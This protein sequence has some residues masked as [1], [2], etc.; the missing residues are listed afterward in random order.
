MRIKSQLSGFSIL[1]L[2]SF[3]IIPLSP[4]HVAAQVDEKEKAQQELEKRKELEHKTLAL[5]DEIVSGAWGLKLPENRSFFLANAADL[6]W[7]YDEKRARNLFWDALNNL[8]PPANLAGNEPTGSLTKDSTTRAAPA[9]DSRAKPPGKEEQQKLNQYYAMFGARREFLRKVAKHDPQLALDMLRSARLPPPPEPPNANFHA[10][11]ERDLEQEIA[12]EAATRDPKRALQIVRESLAKGVTFQL[13]KLLFQLNQQDQEV[14]SEL[15][16][17]IIAKLDGESMETN[18]LVI[19]VQL[20]ESSRTRQS[21]LGQSEPVNVRVKPLKLSDEQKQ[22]LVD[23]ITDAALS[24]SAKENILPT[25][26]WVMPEI[27][28][29]APDRAVKIKAR[30]AQVNRTLTKD[31]QDWNTYNSLFEKAS[32]EEMIKAALR[33]GDEARDSLYREA[34]MKAVMSNKS[35]ALRGFINDNLEDESRKKSLI[36]SLDEQQIGFAAYQGKTEELQRLLPLIRLKE[37]RA[38]AMAELAMLLEKKGNHDEAVQLLDEARALIKVDFN[39]ETQSNALL[40]F[41]L[42]YAVVD[43][44]KAFAIIEPIIDRAND[45]ISKLLLLDK[46]VK[47]GAVKK[48]EIVIAQPGISLDFAMFRYGKGVVALANADF[49]RTK[50]TADRFQRNEL[51][52]IARLMLAHTLLRSLEQVANKNAQ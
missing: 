4:S 7:T 28:Q 26:T 10:P 47:S 45:D 52:L 51:R 19:V 34:V 35:D 30:L 36:D 49:N 31:Q 8:A 21:A 6:L 23:R 39:S 1:L 15:A 42:A 43:P 41:M 16:G 14:A 13:L 44:P 2:L 38:L 50:A 3:F 9:K 20:L 48:G 5:V 18:E 27:E 17:D 37:Q 40:T 25:V 11:D 33:L 46:I 32:P 24:V 22:N 12:E 29:F